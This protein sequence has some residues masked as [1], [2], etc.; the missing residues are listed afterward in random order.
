M[1]AAA[2]VEL[3][4]LGEWLS[5]YC[6]RVKQALAVKGV[7][8]YEYVEEDLEHKSELLLTHN[9]IHKRVPVLLHG[10]RAVLESLV[11]V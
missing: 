1:A 2:G 5:P 4:L 7:A 11:I 10:D 9:P 3:R 8:G 6:I